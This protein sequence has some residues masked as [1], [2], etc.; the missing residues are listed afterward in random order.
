M[1]RVLVE[2]SAEKDIKRLS[3]DVRLRVAKVLRN[4][5]NDPRPVGSR[6]LEDVLADLPKR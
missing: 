2:R 3:P 4:L 6:K 5:A 1:Y